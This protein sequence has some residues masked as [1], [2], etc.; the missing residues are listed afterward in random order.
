MHDEPDYV[1]ELQAIDRK[2]DEID[3]AWQ[4]EIDHVQEGLRATKALLNSVL[5]GEPGA[6]Y[7]EYVAV[8]QEYRRMEESMEVLRR[9]KV[10]R[11]AFEEM[12][13]MLTSAK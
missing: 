7:S 11:E 10:R 3:R 12:K 8:M 9:L 1:V 2:L 6:Q 13:K 5:P 4:K